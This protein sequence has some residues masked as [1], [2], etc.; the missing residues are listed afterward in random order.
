MSTKE[1]ICLDFSSQTLC[2]FLFCPKISKCSA[3]FFCRDLLIDVFWWEE[4][5]MNLI[6][7]N[8]IVLFRQ[9]PF[10]AFFVISQNN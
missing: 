4:E 3:E 2:E 8:G 10:N 7:T 9:C 5:L 1:F 6:L